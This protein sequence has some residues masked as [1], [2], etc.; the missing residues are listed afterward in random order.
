LQAESLRRQ[1]AAPCRGRELAELFNTAGLAEVETG[2]LGG[3]WR[4]GSCSAQEIEAEWETLEEDL[5]GMLPPAELARLKQANAGAWAEGSRVLFVPTFYAVGK[6]I[7]TNEFG[8][9]AMK[10]N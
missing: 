10:Y 5:E 4:R 8:N 9:A 2:V 7:Q 3:Q 6:V 1:G